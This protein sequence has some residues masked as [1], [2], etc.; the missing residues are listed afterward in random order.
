[1]QQ[2]APTEAS[3]TKCVSCFLCCTAPCHVGTTTHTDTE[4]ILFRDHNS[5]LV[6]TMIDDDTFF[7][8]SSSL[9]VKTAT[10][11]LQV[12]FARL[13]PCYYYYATSTIPWSLSLIIKQ[14]G[15]L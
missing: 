10:L 3:R 8:P 11:L 1:M 12:A 13:S 15:L 4:Y 7:I 2:H 5:T 9:G 14:R 6:L